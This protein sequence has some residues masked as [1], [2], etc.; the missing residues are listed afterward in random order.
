MSKP[1]NSSYPCSRLKPNNQLQRR[2][3]ATPSHLDIPGC[4]QSRSAIIDLFILIAV[5][6]ACS[7]LLFPYFKILV[8]TLVR[9]IP[10]IVN[11]VKHEILRTPLIYGY[12]GLCALL[13][14][15]AGLAI[16]VCLSKKCGKP[17]CKGMRKAAEFDIQLETEECLKNSSGLSTNDGGKNG[18][19]ELP[20]DHHKELEA[21]LKKMAPLNGRA[22]IV[23]RARCGCCIGR[24]EVPG[25]RKTRKVKK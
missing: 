21:E 1:S 9:F 11:S 3:R 10:I 7:F 5:V 6:S 16:P 14:V 8:C 22:V 19:F 23:F 13:L 18:L 2:Q 20:R 4:H 24:M 12:M 25:P 15:V 17:G